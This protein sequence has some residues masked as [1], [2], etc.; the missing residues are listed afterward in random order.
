M[1]RGPRLA[2]RHAPER[3]PVEGPRRLRDG[4][5]VSARRE[6]PRRRRS[7]ARTRLAV[8]ATRSS[9]ARR[10][11]CSRRRR[12]STDVSGIGASGKKAADR[13]HMLN[14]VNQALAS[15]ISLEE[16][17]ELILDRA[18]VHLKPQEAAIYLRDAGRQRRLRR[19]PL[20][21]G[22]RVEADALAG[23]SSTRSSTRGWSPTSSTRPST[24]GS[25]RARA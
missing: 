9:T 14:Q 11:S 13:L 6:R 21:P 24:S 1:H 19:P 18:F 23:A 20:D 12:A 7:T 4:D 17:L 3:G 2:Q 16:L 15:S 8:A 5:T 25:P 22:A 10:R